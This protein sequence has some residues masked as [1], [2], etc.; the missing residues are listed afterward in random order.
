MFELSKIEGVEIYYSEDTMYDIAVDEDKTYTANKIVVHNSDIC[1]H[2]NGK[3]LRDFSGYTPPNHFQCR[4]ILVPVT[5]IDGWDGKES[6]KPRVQ[7]HKG[8]F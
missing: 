4:S 5:A 3:I 2:L 7:P 6:P 1:E 8:F